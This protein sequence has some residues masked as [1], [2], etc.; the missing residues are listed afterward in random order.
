M[1]DYDVIVVGGGHNGLVCASYLAKSGRKVLVLEANSVAGGGASTREFTP[2]YSVS[3]CAQ[4]LYQ[5]NPE[6]ASDLGL[7]RHGLEYAARDLDTIGLAA[8]GNIITVGAGGVFGSR[9]SDADKAAFG[10][11]QQRM[12]K[13]AK[14]LNGAFKRRAPKL[15]ENNLHDR[16]TLLKLGID[17]KLLG[18]NDMQ[19]L[20]RL[21]LI[22]MYDVMEETFDDELLK[23]VLA[24][25][26]VMGSYMGPRSPNTVFGYIY[27]QLG[28]VYGF[29]GPA[30]VKGGMGAVGAAFAAAA[31]SCGVEI[32]TDCRVAS[33]D[34]NAD[35]A[36]GV[37]LTDGTTLT[38]ATVVSNADPKT[39]FEK[40]VGFRHIEAGTTRRVSTIRMKG[41]AAK[42]HLALDGLP[43]FTGLSGDQLGQRLV[44]APTMKYVEDAFNHAK[45]GEYSQA[46][47]MDI[48]IPTVNDPGLAPDGKHVLSATIQFAPYELRAGWD[49]N[50]ATFEQLCIDVLAK[51]A[52]NI[53]SL[54]TASELLTPA[55]LEAEY[56]MYGGHWHHGE[57]SLDQIMMMRPFPGATQ[58]ATP[59]DNLYLC[60][61][62][63]HPGG[64]VMGLA[65][66][67]AAK[68]IIKRGKAA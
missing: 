56:N 48:S 35:S 29:T 10:P 55:D 11:F 61:A 13:F 64:G 28:Q 22:N 43:E 36:Q 25:D 15:V 68:E 50:K 58:Y 33:I 30:Q 5:L 18:K 39:T 63:A 57:I 67:N 65:G 19:E 38:A 23:S 31:E 45:Y 9:L 49:S 52:P 17:M 16:M 6:V 60:S 1:T 8:D 59:V 2:G 27:R 20:L 3:G 46:P 41:N 54:I 34:L 32:R 14:L 21:A 51:Y 42:L 53:R 12:V 7:V 66:R 47:A 37:T 62:G 44:I 4:W 26:G 24:L 40:L